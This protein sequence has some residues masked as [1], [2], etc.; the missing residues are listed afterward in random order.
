MEWKD[1]RRTH[2]LLRESQDTLTRGEQERR[3]ARVHLCFLITLTGHLSLR[4]TLGIWIALLLDRVL[5]FQSQIRRSQL[6]RQR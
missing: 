3:G 1:G 6:R 4:A 5:L 2:T